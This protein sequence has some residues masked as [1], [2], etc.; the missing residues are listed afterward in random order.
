MDIINKQNVTILRSKNGYVLHNT[1]TNEYTDTVYLTL[2]SNIDDYEEVPDPNYTDKLYNMMKTILKNEKL[3]NKIAKIIAAEITDDEIAYDIQDIYDDWEIGISY[4]KDQYVKYHMILY[5]IL[6]DH[7]SQRDWTPDKMH[8]LYA[9]VLIDPTGETIPEWERPNSTNAYMTGDK[10]K[11]E[12]HIYE[13]LIDN[14]IWSPSA[15]PAG[16]KLIE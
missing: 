9:K 3:L 10:V 8:S 1:V 13:S 2:N 12:E 11:F 5:K 14:N 15:Y 4:K 16:W 7:T 6:T